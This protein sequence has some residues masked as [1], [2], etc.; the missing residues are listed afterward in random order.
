MTIVVTILVSG[1]FVARPAGTDELAADVRALESR[2][3]ALEE[4]LAGI[5]GAARSV[6]TRNAPRPPAEAPPRPAAPPKVESRGDHAQVPA[7][8]APRD[9]PEHLPWNRPDVRVETLT[10]R[11]EVDQGTAAGLAKVYRER[12]DGLLRIWRDA[13]A[14]GLARH[15]AMRR[16]WAVVKASDEQMAK[17]LTPEQLVKFKQMRMRDHPRGIDF[18]AHSGKPGEKPAP[19]P[20]AED[21]VF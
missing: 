14:K 1:F 10:E 7:K 18:G 21:V 6:A 17:L 9:E 11:L 13:P 16:V 3:V 15:E 12:Q 4:R 5:S 20:D 2:I 19:E 8:A